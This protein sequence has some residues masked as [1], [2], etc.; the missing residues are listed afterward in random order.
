MGPAGLIY[1]FIEERPYRRPSWRP[2]RRPS[3]RPYRR[4]Y[5]RPSWRQ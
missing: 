3:W 5:R 4:P 2:Y 1:F